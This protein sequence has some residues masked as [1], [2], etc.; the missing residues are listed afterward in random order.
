MVTN[1][2]AVCASQFDSSVLKLQHMQSVKVALKNRQSRARI[3]IKKLCVRM[4]VGGNPS[5]GEQ[6]QGTAKGPKRA[7]TIWCGVVKGDLG[8]ARGVQPRCEGD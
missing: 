6:Q 4:S 7:L 1:R 2:D 3:T 5:H 8:R